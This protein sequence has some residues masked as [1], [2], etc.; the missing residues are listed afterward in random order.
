MRYPGERIPVDIR[1][2]NTMDGRICAGAE[3]RDYW[4]DVS[5]KF[6]VYKHLKLRHKVIGAH[7]D[8][9]AGQWTLIVGN[10]ENGEKYDGTFDVVIAAIGRFNA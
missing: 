7:W 9:N 10:L 6:D 8:D 1:S 5:R 3:I 2:E 4:Q